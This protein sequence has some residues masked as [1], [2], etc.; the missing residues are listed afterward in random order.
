METDLSTRIVVVTGAR[1]RLGR[2]VSERL[3][4]AGASVA[5]LDVVPPD[6][7]PAGAMPIGADLADEGDV[8]EAFS[9]IEGELGAPTGLVH[10]VG[11]WDGAPLTATTL[12]AW[13][14]IIRVNL[15][16]TFLCFREASRAM[17]RA[18]SGGRLVAIASRQGADRAPSEQAA[19]AASKA[20]VMRLVEASAA[21]YASE[22]I[23]ACAIA[24][25]TILFGDEDHGTRGVPAT[26]VVDL[27]LYLCGDGGSVHNGT[28]LRT[29]GDG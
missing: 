3:L 11:M 26:A 17:R 14:R 8:A 5:A 1:G 24:P 12:D 16:S 13:E 10:T 4:E 19:Y 15:T 25:S 20:G 29:Y 27:C 21:E 18:G 28:V 22:G 23:T 6:D 7:L 9:R 2:L